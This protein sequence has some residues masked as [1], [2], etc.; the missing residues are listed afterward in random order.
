MTRKLALL[1]VAA[2]VLASMMFAPVQ[3]GGVRVGIGIGIPGPFWAAITITRTRTI[4]TDI[5]RTIRITIRITPRRRARLSRRLTPR[6]PTLRRRILRQLRRAAADLRRAAPT[7]TP[8]LCRRRTTRLR[9]RPKCRR[10]RSP[11]G[12]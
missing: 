9:L 2:L 11:V 8:P 7:Y 4:H 1:A 10:I 5:I 12:N 6:R 3:A